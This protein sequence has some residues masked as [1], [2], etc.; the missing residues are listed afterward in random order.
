MDDDWFQAKTLH[1]QVRK[2]GLENAGYAEAEIVIE[3]IGP[4]DKKEDDELDLFLD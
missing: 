4:A 3:T 1:Q 2:Q